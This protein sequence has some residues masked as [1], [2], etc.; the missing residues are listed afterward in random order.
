MRSS[1]TTPRSKSAFSLIELLV[2]VA[3]IALLLALLL[4][5]LRNARDVAKSA[6]CASNLRQIMLATLA[7]TDDSNGAL[8]RLDV[9]YDNYNVIFGGQDGVRDLLYQT[10]RPLNPYLGLPARCGVIDPLGAQPRNEQEAA[11]FSCPSDDGIDIV[12][13][14]YYSQFGNSYQ[15]NIFLIGGSIF[16]IPG[17]PLSPV[18][19][20][21]AQRVQPLA[22]SAI[23][24][25]PSRLI[26]WGDGVW[27]RSL[28]FGPR[29]DVVWHRTGCSHNMAFL[30]GHA[31]LVRLRRGY[32]VWSDYSQIPFR[33]LAATA[34]NRQDR[35]LNPDDLPCP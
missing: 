13:P 17:D 24:E 19:A 27:I 11:V 33:D 30:D 12:R 1:A 7:Y 4:P 35:L 10:P 28:N 34:Q 6:A 22:V 31:A 25:D 9:V 29:E 14:T 18:I 2:V 5:S 16:P 23:S 21:V 3:I 15:A 26:V 8:P 20:R 32:R